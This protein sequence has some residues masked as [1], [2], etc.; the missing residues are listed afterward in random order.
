MSQLKAGADM[1]IDRLHAM[2]DAEVQAWPFIDYHG[3]KKARLPEGL[4]AEV[5]TAAGCKPE[6]L[7]VEIASVHGD[8]THEVHYHRDT[9]AFVA[10]LGPAEK[11]PT[12]QKAQAFIRK[13]FDFTVGQTV[14][15]PPNTPH[16]FTVGEGGVLYFLSIQSPPIVGEDGQDDYF[17][18]EV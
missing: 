4:V 12:P 5:A 14:E 11:F 10:C 8:L 17:H 18:P 3:F 1:I 7:Q 6:E 2:S 15:I 16:G 13:W 9:T